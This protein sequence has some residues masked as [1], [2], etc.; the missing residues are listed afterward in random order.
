MDF[1]SRAHLCLRLLVLLLLCAPHLILGHLWSGHPEYDGAGGTD[2]LGF[3]V[4]E[5]RADDDQ[6][7]DGAH[8][9]DGVR[10]IEVVLQEA[11]VASRALL[12]QAK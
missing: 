9:V 4:K 8:E 10:R 5:E 11:R 12:G 7:F 2:S 6:G 3:V 1:C